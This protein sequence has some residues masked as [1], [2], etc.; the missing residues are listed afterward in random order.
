MV[1]LP[2]LFPLLRRRKRKKRQPL[3]KEKTSKRPQ[4]LKAPIRSPK[5][6]LR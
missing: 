5:P 2:R 6:T 4:L 3:L 1:S